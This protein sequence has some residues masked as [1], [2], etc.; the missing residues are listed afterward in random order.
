MQRGCSESSAGAEGDLEIK[1]QLQALGLEE[2]APAPHFD[3]GISL[4]ISRVYKPCSRPTLLTQSSPSPGSPRNPQNKRIPG[5]RVTFP[6]LITR[7]ISAGPEAQLNLG[8]TAWSG[9]FSWDWWLWEPGRAAPHLPEWSPVGNE[10]H[11]GG[12]LL[13]GLRQGM[14]NER[15][16]LGWGWMRHCSRLKKKKNGISAAPLKEYLLFALFLTSPSDVAPKQTSGF[17]NCGAFLG[18]SGSQE[19]NFLDL[20]QQ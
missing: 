3:G 8:G 19:L 16:C 13:I 15:F 1:E 7:V 10:L 18:K 2:K 4:H 14:R 12:K 17:W 6:R 20:E 9:S 11:T 5:P